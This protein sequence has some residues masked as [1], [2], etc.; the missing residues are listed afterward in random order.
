MEMIEKLAKHY[1]I[2]PPGQQGGAVLMVALV[3]LVIITLLGLT[4][5]RTNIIETQR[6]KLQLTLACCAME[7]GS[8]QVT[9][10]I[11]AIER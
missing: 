7:C 2:T 1:R 9:R 6:Q 5:M 10:A 11:G 8:K 4:A 3:F